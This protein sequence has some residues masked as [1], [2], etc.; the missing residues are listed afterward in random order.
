[1]GG[2][3]GPGF[4]TRVIRMGI[5]TIKGRSEV[6]EP[7]AESESLWY[8]N[9]PK[10]LNRTQCWAADCFTGVFEG[11]RPQGFSHLVSMGVVPGSLSIGFLV[12]VQ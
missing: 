12:S 11:C 5:P 3:A 6:D 4:R 9:L 7:K 10:T 1:M 2:G 8:K